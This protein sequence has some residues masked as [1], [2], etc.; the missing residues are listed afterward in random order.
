MKAI[1]SLDEQLASSVTKYRGLN[2]LI[3]SHVPPAAGL[4]SSSAFTVCA[5]LVML[6]V[7]D[8]QNQI[9][10]DKLSKLCITAERKA[11]TACGGM[12]QTISIM[13]EMN[14]AKI[15]DFNPK[16]KATDVEIPTSV[17]LVIANSL[18]PSPKLATLYKRY[19]MRVVECRL[20]LVIL[21][22]KLGKA[23]SPSK[24]PYKTFYELQ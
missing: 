7:Y 17:L 2:I 12:D 16:L 10:K 6:H 8:L 13:G 1:L 3:D 5:A 4:S 14:K 19:N 15:I 20:A 18:A 23:D 22:V 24:V 9:P 21:A 11:G